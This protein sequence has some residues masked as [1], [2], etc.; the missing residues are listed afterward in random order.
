MKIVG[1]NVNECT[2]C[3]ACESTCS[4]FYY[5]EDNRQK[6]TI[7]VEELP[8]QRGAAI[9]VCNQCGDCIAI[10]PVLAIKKSQ[11]GVVVLNKKLC[12]GCYNCVGVCPTGTMFWHED[13]TEPF[14]CIACARCTK[15]CPT[16]A[17]FMQ[18]V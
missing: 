16:E 7:Q 1:T 9:S 17:I 12:I 8:D 18:E 6:S 5:K 15:E 11:S 14:K 13:L 4:T 10:C 2:L 3:G